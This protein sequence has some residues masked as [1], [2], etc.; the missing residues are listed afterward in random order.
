[1]NHIIL[2]SMPDG[3]LAA[4]WDAFLTDAPFATHYVMPD[5]FVDPFAGRGERFAILAVEGDQ[6]NAV[7]TGLKANN[8]IMS[9]L[10]V[11]PQTAF[12]DGVDR[13][14]AA[15]SLIEGVKEFAGEAVDLIRLY[16]WEPITGLDSYGYQHEM[17]FGAD[18]IVMLDLAKGPNA[19]FMEF[20]ERRRTDLRKVMRQ[21]KLD[22]KL[23]EPKPSW[24]SFTK[25][26]KTGIVAKGMILIRSTRSRLY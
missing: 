2:T 26:I 10:A 4:K 6:I 5:F 18:N 16:S 3:D 19:L 24:Q 8:K 13:A 1:M 15:D 11:R 7:M 9:G 21:G 17:C 25:F 14:A 12:R 22:V 20:S 23:L